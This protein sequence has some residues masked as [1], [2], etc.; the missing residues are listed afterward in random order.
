MIDELFVWWLWVFK[1]WG[2]VV[3]DWCGIWLLCV[4]DVF[5]VCSEYDF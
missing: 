2:D 3:D 5:V 1:V 4:E